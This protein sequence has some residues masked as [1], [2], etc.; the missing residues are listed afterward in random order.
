MTKK[1]MDKKNDG[2]KI[3]KTRR[4]NVIFTSLNGQKNR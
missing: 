4:N 2:Q 1:P 3:Q